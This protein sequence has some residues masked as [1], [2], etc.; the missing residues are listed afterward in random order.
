MN[1]PKNNLSVSTSIIIAGLLIAGG[2]YLSG[3]PAQTLQNTNVVKNNTD[4]TINPVTNKDHIQGNPDA[5][6]VVVEYS[7]LECP[8]CKLFQSTMDG[9]IKTFGKDGTVAWVYRHFF[10]HSKAPL[11]AEAAECVN[12]LGGS[13]AFWKM[14]GIFYTESPLNDGLDPAK[15]PDFAKEAGVD[16]TKFN[17][18]LVSGKY[19]SLVQA[20][21]NDAVKSGGRGTPYIVMVLK[22][23]ITT[24]I[25]NKIDQY[26]I[27]N[28]IIDQQS[29]T[30][31]IF[32][33]NDM[34]KVVVGGALPLNMM[35]DLINMI[36]GK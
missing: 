20:D 24:D 15:L 14:V 25:K 27:T 10:I 9:I 33:S 29:G 6:I 23:P 19:T 21:S 3:R 34:T 12:E 22:T 32:A 30:P 5:P 35:T 7:D 28:Q 18:C 26:V 4:V 1:E 16:V 31:L 2:I 17:S 11:E 13:T 8:Y 36:L